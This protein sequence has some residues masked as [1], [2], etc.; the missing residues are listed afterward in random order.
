MKLASNEV[1]S[2]RAS[3]QAP[4]FEFTAPPDVEKPVSTTHTAQW[5]WVI[6]PKEKHLG[7]QIVLADV[8]LRDS[9]QTN[10]VRQ[11]PYL[12]CSINVTGPFGLPAW[13]VDMGTIAMAL[14]VS[15][16]TVLGILKGWKELKKRQ[17]RNKKPEQDNQHKPEPPPQ[18]TT[19]DV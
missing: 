17:R 16:G 7:S 11:I 18:P 13:A 6:T 19:K 14:L 4:S 3:L 15:I 9:K 1:Y 10:V 12:R 5:A 8:F 2:A